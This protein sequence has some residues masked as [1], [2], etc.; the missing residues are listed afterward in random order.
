LIRCIRVNINFGAFLQPVVALF[1]CNACIGVGSLW[2]NSSQ[3]PYSTKNG[4]DDL[5]QHVSSLGRFG[6]TAFLIP[7]Y[8]SG[9]LSQAFCRSGVVF[10]LPRLPLLI[11]VKTDALH[12]DKIVPH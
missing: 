5:L 11:S 3:T 10:M 7:M 8:G 6:D 12:H 9:E 2:S 1:R 4:V